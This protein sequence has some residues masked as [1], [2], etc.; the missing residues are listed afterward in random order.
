MKVALV[1]TDSNS[2]WHFRKGLIKGLI[3]K[4]VN[5]HI[6]TPTGPYIKNLKLLGV[7]HRP[8][9]VTRFLNPLS[10][11]KYFINL[12]CIFYREQYDIVHNFSIKPNTYGAMVARLAGIDKVLGSVTGLGYLF[13]KRRSI[14]VHVLKSLVMGLYRIGFKCTDRIWFQN[15]DDI[16]EF[17]S[18]GI[19]SRD[20]VALIRSSGVDT[21]TFSPARVDRNVLTSFKREFALNGHK[22]ITMVARPL[23]SKGIKEFI[24]AYYILE[25]SLPNAT[26]IVVGEKEPGNPD[27]VPDGYIRK[28][29]SERLRFIGWRDE[30]RE[31][32][33]SS[34][35]VVLPSHREGTPKS[36]IEAMAMGK[37]L[38]ATDTAGC[39]EVVEH[40]KNG[41]LVPVGDSRKLA[42]AI[43]EIASNGNLARDYGRY[44]RQKAVRE[45]E[46]K[47]V[48]N[49]IIDEV[50]QI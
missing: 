39:K 48:V 29:Q 21:E 42:E 13:A 46:E 12:Y 36:L 32:Y 23:W 37:A 7:K 50:Y 35:I 1:V 22:I 10:D 47:F 20:K 43:Y 9:K 49:R 2:A 41:M 25:N 6:I 44:S 15:P 34:S 5:V 33:A 17:V 14:K 11:L 40:Q 16:N 28:N 3:I 38:I 24:E 19:I 18:A 8:V 27:N 45:F 30:M 31:I 26:F 4:G